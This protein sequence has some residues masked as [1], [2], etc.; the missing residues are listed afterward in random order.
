MFFLLY[1]F[2]FCDALAFFF[3]FLAAF[4]PVGFG[5]DAGEVRRS[6]RELGFGV[7]SGCWDKHGVGQGRGA[8]AS[9]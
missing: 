8:G 1:F 6:G 9:S 3:L 5:V 7:R 2:F 4:F